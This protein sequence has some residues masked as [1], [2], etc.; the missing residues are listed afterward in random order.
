MRAATAIRR[1]YSELLDLAAAG[2]R[3]RERA[4]TP[5]EFLVHLRRLFPDH[6]AEVEAITGAYV[7]VRYGQV[8][9]GEDA[10]REVRRCWESVHRSAW[11][12]GVNE[13]MGASR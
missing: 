4:E 1:I 8:P 2:G 7:Q 13:S 3:P 11:P 6:T 9:E 5:L 12:S 10:V